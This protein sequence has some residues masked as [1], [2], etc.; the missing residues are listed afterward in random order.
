VYQISSRAFA[1]AREVVD[2]AGDATQ[3]TERA[4]E[5]DEQLTNLWPQTSDAAALDPG[6]SQAWS[7]AR[8]DLTYV[9]S[10]GEISGT[11]TRLFA[12]LQSRQT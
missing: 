7:D 12:Y 2:G 10:G 8:L 3:R 5:L 1:L 4:R 9:L 6:L 11:S